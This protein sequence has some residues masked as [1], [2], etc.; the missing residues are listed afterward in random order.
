MPRPKTLKKKIPAFRTDNEERM[1]WEKASPG[2]YIHQ[3]RATKVR[4]SPQFRQQVKEKKLNLT[5]RM[6]PSRVR[7]LKAAAHYHGIP[8]QTLMRMWIVERLRK[9]PAGVGITVEA[10]Q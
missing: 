3:T 6:E 5:L 10:L 7:A 9:E 4:V 1:F 2:E 8:Y